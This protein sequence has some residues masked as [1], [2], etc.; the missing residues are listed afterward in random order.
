MEVVEL[1]VLADVD[2]FTRPQGTVA[3]AAPTGRTNDC[4]D[5]YSA[6]LCRRLGPVGIPGE[7]AVN[8]GRP[9][10]SGKDCHSRRWTRGELKRMSVVPVARSL[11]CGRGPQCRSA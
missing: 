2:R 6:R 8:G 7:A 11:G 10:G 5:R 3:G 9:A 4:Q 1:P